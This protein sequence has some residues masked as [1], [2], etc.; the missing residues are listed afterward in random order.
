MTMTIRPASTTVAAGT[1][2]CASMIAAATAVPAGRSE[3]GG[4]RLRQAADAPPGRHDL[5]RELRGQVPEARVQRGEELRRRE[6]ALAAPEALVAGAAGVAHPR[7]RELADDPVAA[8][9][10]RRRGVVD[11]GILLEDLE[12]LGREPLRGALAAVVGEK[13]LAALPG[14]RVD[15]VGL[16]L[17]RVVLPELGPRVR[18]RRPLRQQTERPARPVDRQDRAGG[19]VDADPDDR[20]LRDA[21]GGERL[22]HGLLDRR[23]PVARVLQRPVGAQPDARVRQCRVDH[24]VRILHDGR[25]ALLPGARLDDERPNGRRAEVE[26]ERAG[27]LR[28]R[29]ARYF[30]AWCRS[31]DCS[32][33]PHRL[34]CM[35]SARAIEAFRTS[36]RLA[37]M[38][39]GA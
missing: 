15:P 19:E 13:R 18:A 9:D 5:A 26:P 20:L 28:F 34:T 37:V 10:D 30:A 16:R 23:D 21:R 33:S 25:A 36:A 1:A 24:A 39:S 17:R 2:L 32:G 11:L 29:H 27:R 38:A 35:P 3:P 8:L 31:S 22:R 6:P 4:H 12:R 7:P 14:E